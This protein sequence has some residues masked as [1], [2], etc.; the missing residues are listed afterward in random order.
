MKTISFIVSFV[1]TACG[2]IKI[3]SHFDALNFYQIERVKNST[4]KY[5]TAQILL[6]NKVA[7]LQDDLS[8]FIFAT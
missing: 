6:Q 2:L 4:G 3:Y 8:V 7:K 1:P 5:K